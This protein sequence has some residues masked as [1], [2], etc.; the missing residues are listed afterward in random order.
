MNK[1]KKILIGAIVLGFCGAIIFAFLQ[2]PL[3]LQT[4]EPQN[5]IEDYQLIKPV[6]DYHSRLTWN[7][8]DYLRATTLWPDLTFRPW[9]SDLIYFSKKYDTL[10]TKIANLR[11][12]TTSG[13]LCIDLMQ[14]A[15]QD[16]RILCTGNF[17][18]S[19]EHIEQIRQTLAAAKSRLDELEPQQPKPEIK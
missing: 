14:K 8:S 19:H 12:T 15:S 10:S 17:N 1:H 5:T 11:P 13:Q 7:F 18:I 3:L 9:K 2:S 4:P 6:Y 16:A